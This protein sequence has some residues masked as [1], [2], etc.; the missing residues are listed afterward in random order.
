MIRG[1]LFDINGTLTDILTNE[2]D[3]NIYRVLSHFFLYQGISLSAN[4]IKELYFEINKCQRHNSKEDFPE[5]DIVALFDEIITQ[6]ASTYTETLPRKKRKL[7]SRTAAE[8]F[9][10]A[11]LFQLQ[12]YPSVKET[13]K[14]LKKKYRLAA[15]SDGQSAWA[16]A[17]LNAVGLLDFFDPLIVS[18]DY[19]YRKPDHRL[20]KKALKKINMSADEVIFIGN[21]LYRDVY[22]ANLAGMKSV[23]FES[24]QGDH[25]FDKACPDYVIHTFE[26]LETAIRQLA[27]R[28][29]KEKK[30]P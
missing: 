27:L 23:F 5:F 8:I 26:E 12:L 28:A 20:F 22:G 30:H 24:N 13:L 21:D 1:L 19:G 7:L 17:E 6:S 18:G 4:K 11:S 2:G 10:A 16:T 29:K 14:R 15:V 25:S 9:R 3:D